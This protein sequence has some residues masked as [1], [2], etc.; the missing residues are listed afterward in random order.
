MGTRFRM[1]HG[2]WEVCVHGVS[3][4]IYMSKLHIISTTHII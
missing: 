3:V 4:I 1:C 2:G